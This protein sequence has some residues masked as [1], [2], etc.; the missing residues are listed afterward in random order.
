LFYITGKVEQFGRVIMG[1]KDIIEQG[2]LLA[3][4]PVDPAKFTAKVGSFLQSVGV[5]VSN[6][7]PKVIDK[8]CRLFNYSLS[9]PT[10]G[11]FLNDKNILIY[12]AETGIGKSV[13]VQHY[14]AMLK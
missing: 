10:L 3:I 2:L 7:T 14:V 1:R 13:A 6:D 11:G 8:L 9:N 4:T 12:P 5:L